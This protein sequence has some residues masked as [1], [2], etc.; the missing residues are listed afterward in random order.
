MPR[1]HYRGCLATLKGQREPMS[2]R[3]LRDPL[4]EVILKLKMEG[5][6]IS[7][8]EELQELIMRV[9]FYDVNINTHTNDNVCK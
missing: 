6:I 2:L 3:Q 8:E 9:R 5:T 1:T 7:T 4:N